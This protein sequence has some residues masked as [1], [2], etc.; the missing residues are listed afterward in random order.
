MES[1]FDKTCHNIK[2]LHHYLNYCIDF[3]LKFLTLLIL[4][5][6]S[7]MKSLNYPKNSYQ[8]SKSEWRYCRFLKVL[9]TY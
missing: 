9:L 4:D 7:E 1:D 8:Y 5:L 6:V 2:P 3:I